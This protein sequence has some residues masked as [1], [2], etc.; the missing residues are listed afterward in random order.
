MEQEEKYLASGPVF[1]PVNEFS[2]SCFWDVQTTPYIRCWSLARKR[3]ND[4]VL[5]LYGQDPETFHTLLFTSGM[6]TIAAIVDAYSRGAPEDSVILHG[7]EM[8]SDV[9]YSAHYICGKKIKTRFVSV[10]DDEAVLSRFREDGNKL[11]VFII[12]VC[13]NA[14][15]QIFNFDLIPQLHQLAPDCLIVVDNTW[16]SPVACNP[17]KYGVDIVVESTTKHISGCSAIGGIATGSRRALE[18]LSQWMAFFGI[19]VP[20]EQC[21]IIER[22]LHSIATRHQHA[23]TLALATA[24]WMQQEGPE[25]SNR[26]LHPLLPSHPCHQRAL[27]FFSSDIG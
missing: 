6:N 25:M 8:Y 5:K 12:E 20:S 27:K 21:L 9:W 22:Q 1:D 13:T 11:L 18:P 3:V 7:S 15:G 14:S 26:V 4:S 24:Q 16:L 10:Q 2:E 19:H 23:S 17:F